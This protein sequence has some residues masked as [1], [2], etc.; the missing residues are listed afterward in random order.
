MKG[1][2]I[3]ALRF[4]VNGLDRTIA[5]PAATRLSECLRDELGLTGT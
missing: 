5:S 3:P 4:R 1:E 2:P